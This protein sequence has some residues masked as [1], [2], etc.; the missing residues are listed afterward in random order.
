VYRMNRG[1]AGEAIGEL[2]MGVDHHAVQGALAV[3][4]VA[5]SVA[6]AVWPRGRRCSA[7]SPARARATSAS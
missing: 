5:L 6:A 4:L 3:A 1:D 2:T 7:S